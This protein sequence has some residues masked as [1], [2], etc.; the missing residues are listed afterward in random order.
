MIKIDFL[1]HFMVYFGIIIVLL[2]FAFGAFVIFSPT[3]NY[4]PENFRTIFG[5]VIIAYG[6]FRLVNI[7]WKF[8]NK[9]K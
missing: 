1:S 9:E 8:K 6:F 3:L 4:V 7:Y 2:F 5:V